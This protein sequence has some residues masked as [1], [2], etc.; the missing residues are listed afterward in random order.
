MVHLLEI[1][2]KFLFG[3]TMYYTCVRRKQFKR[4]G[5]ML[6]ENILGCYYRNNLMYLSIEYVSI[7]LH[8]ACH[9][10]YLL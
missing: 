9:C 1:S 4:R 6:H 5:V 2:E 10:V 7:S 8:L 3:A